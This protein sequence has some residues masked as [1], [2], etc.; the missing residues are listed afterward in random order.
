MA[1]PL[2]LLALAV[3]VRVLQGLPA[4]VDAFEHDSLLLLVLL[5]LLVVLA[6]LLL[7]LKLLNWSHHVPWSLPRLSRLL[8]WYLVLPPLPLLLMAHAWAWRMAWRSE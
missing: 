4:Q 6:L 5:P 1:V 8:L 7:L 3:Q 2:Q